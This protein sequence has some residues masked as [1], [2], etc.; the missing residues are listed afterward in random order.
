MD[1]VKEVV[2]IV[3]P[4]YNRERFVE[5]SVQS[6]L[7]QTHGNVE[8]IIVDD[9][10][11]DRSLEICEEQFAAMEQIR[12]LRHDKNLGQAASVNDGIHAATGKYLM[13]LH[14]DD[15]LLPDA[16]EQLYEVAERTGADVVHTCVGVRARG[17][18][19]P[20]LSEENDLQAVK[21]DKE[22][23]A[24]ET[25]MSATPEDRMK[26]WL[27]RRTFVDSVYNLFRRELLTEN[28]IRFE[29]AGGNALFCFVWLMTARKV[30]K[31]AIPTYVYREHE[32]SVSNAGRDDSFVGEILT[33]MAEIVSQA[34]GYLRRIP[35]FEGRPKQ[36]DLVKIALLSTHDN[37]WTVRLGF[38]REGMT[39]GVDRAVSQAAEQLFGEHAFLL[40]YLF[41]A[42]HEQQYGRFLEDD[43]Y[44]LADSPA[45]RVFTCRVK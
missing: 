45:D 38:Y 13:I 20:L 15:V 21:I 29:E 39:E 12:I 16:V 17:T 31:T 14:S 18:A 34:D 25:E 11:T 5:D 4:V 3:I 36:R 35:W 40:S 1:S 19:M 24:E 30:V 10:S 26:E 8:V 37:W 22:I 28:E 32:A 41:H 2:S 33:Q 6:A 43:A 27:E 44:Y 7:H 9:G 23:V 42:W